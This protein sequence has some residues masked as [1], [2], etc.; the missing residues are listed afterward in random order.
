MAGNAFICIV[1]QCMIMLFQRSHRRII[2]A[3][4]IKIF[5]DLGDVDPGRTGQASKEP[6]SRRS[7]KIHANLSD[8]E[9]QRKNSINHAIFMYYRP[10]LYTGRGALGNELVTSASLKFILKKS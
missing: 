2:Q 5:V 6:S 8:R 10:S 9:L 4:H 7:G 3:R 1:F